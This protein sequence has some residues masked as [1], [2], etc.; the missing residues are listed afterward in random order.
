MPPIVPLAD[1]FR[2]HVQTG[3]GSFVIEAQEPGDIVGAMLRK[4]VTEIAGS[5]LRPGRHA[6][7]S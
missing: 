4:F 2:A 7:A 6:P 5:R 1:Y 3:M